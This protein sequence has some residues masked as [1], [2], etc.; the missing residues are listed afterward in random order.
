MKSYN[1]F[2]AAGKPVVAQMVPLSDRDTSLRT[3][4]GGSSSTP[5]QWLAFTAPLPA[6]GYSAFFL[7]PSATL[8]AAPHT[9]ASI[10][11]RIAVGDSVITNGRISITVSAATGMLSSYADATTGV[12]LP[13]QQQ[14]LT[15]IGFDGKS[16]VGREG[17]KGILGVMWRRGGCREGGMKIEAGRTMIFYRVVNNLLLSPCW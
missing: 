3:L 7:V 8:E 15:Y 12:S 9:H 6:A 2:D 17:G 13:L 5:V 4:Y 11:T 14:W 1:V 16:K 10:V